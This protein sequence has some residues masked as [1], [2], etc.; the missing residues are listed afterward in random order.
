M[1]FSWW[2]AVLALGVGLAP[3]AGCTRESDTPDARV[4]GL[5]SGRDAPM[6]AMACTDRADCN[7]GFPCTI[8]TCTVMNRCEWRPVDSECPMDQ[9]CA[10]G[11]GCVTSTPTDCMVDDDCDDDRRCTG[12]EQCLL[13]VCRTTEEYVCD[14]GNACTVDSC[15]GPSDDCVFET[16]CDSGVGGSD[17]GPVC[18]PFDAGSVYSGTFIVPMAPS[19]GCAVVPTY[20]A[21]PIAF[22]ISGGVLTARATGFTMTQSPAPTGADFDVR[23]DA[24]CAHFRLTG[25]FGCSNQGM[26]MFTADFDPECSI[27]RDQSQSVMLLR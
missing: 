24:G 4:I 17:A 19:Q 13:G 27:C 16:I 18:T 23:S 12:R 7:D 14:D 15:G 9:R 8:D 20:T 22:S 1:R 5:D 6:T 2:F 11:M 21:S 3:Q 25:T 10:V 26:A